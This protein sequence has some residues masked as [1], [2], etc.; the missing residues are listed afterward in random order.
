MKLVIP[1]IILVEFFR[2]CK[3][4]VNEREELGK[5]LPILTF[6]GISVTL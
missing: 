1:G 4:Y 3:Y 5:Y 6:S 2:V